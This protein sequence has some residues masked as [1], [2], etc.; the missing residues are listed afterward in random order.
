MKS[1]SY[2]FAGAAIA[3]LIPLAATAPVSSGAASAPKVTTLNVGIV[4]SLT[5]GLINVAQTQGYF[6]AVGVKVNVT[7]A[8]SGAAVVTGVTA[9]TY[10]VGYTAMTPPL[11]AVANGAPL[12]FVVGQDTVG[13]AGTNGCLLVTK[14][15]GIT[16]AKQLAGAT[17]ASNAPH[18]FASL[19]ALG[20]IANAGG[21]TSNVSISPTDF[22]LMAD[23]LT[24]GAIQ[25]AS[26]IFPFCSEIQA[27]LPSSIIN[28]GD[29]E[30][31]TFP[32]GTPYAMFFTSQSSW[33]GAK[34]NAIKGFASAMSKAVTYGN[35]HLSLVAKLGGIDNGEPA[36]LA[37]ATPM[38]K[39]RATVT[40]GSLKTVLYN[41]K[42]FGWISAA[43]D[44]TSFFSTTN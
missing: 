9:G 16:S 6:K 24:T 27:A 26:D 5:W 17:V 7:P 36:A 28:L 13:A 23:E 43:P 20:A 18:S 41:M 33:D 19:A 29:P 3:L 44:L 42:R 1:S 32:V 25:A 10:D 4:P 34:K 2:R 12:H 11:S 35:A 8:D 38:A 37:A 40:A 15:S 30:A 14:K 31:M 21:D 39:F 22:N